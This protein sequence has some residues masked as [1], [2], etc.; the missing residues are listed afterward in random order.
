MLLEKLVSNAPSSDTLQVMAKQLP[1]GWVGLEYG[2]LPHVSDAAQLMNDAWGKI[3]C[4]S[5]ACWKHARCL[6][7]NESTCSNTANNVEQIDQEFCGT[8]EHHPFIPATVRCLC[9]PHAQFKWSRC[10]DK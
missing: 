9:S 7:R 1:A 4:T 10:A 6:D 3:T 2:N 5:D 8:N